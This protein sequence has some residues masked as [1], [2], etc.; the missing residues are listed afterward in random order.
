MWICSSNSR[1]IFFPFFDYDSSILNGIRVLNNSTFIM[2][3]STRNNRAANSD[4]I[5]HVLM[6]CRV[7]PVHNAEGSK[8]IER[9]PCQPSVNSSSSGSASSNG[10]AISSIP[11]D[12]HM[13]DTCGPRQ[14]T[15]PNLLVFSVTL[16][17]SSGSLS[18]IKN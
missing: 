16:L 7:N 12:G 18:Q 2:L 14:T 8:T 11:S 3:C 15:K 13:R 17:E 6:Q 10:F 9:L 5:F 4:H 1:R